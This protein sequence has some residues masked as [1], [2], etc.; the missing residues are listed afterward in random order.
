MTTETMAFLVR[1][2]PHQI[3][4]GF[5]EPASDV[6]VWMR[7]GDQMSQQNRAL[8]QLGWERVTELKNLHIWE[9]RQDE[10]PL[11]LGKTIVINASGPR[12]VN[13]ATGSRRSRL[14]TT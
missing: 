7:R 9:P 14:R 6:K 1:A 10:Q 8:E 2:I 5:V 13:R 11:E 12:T 4:V 3:A